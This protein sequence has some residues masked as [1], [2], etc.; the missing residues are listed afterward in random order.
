MSKIDRSECSPLQFNSWKALTLAFVLAF[1]LA[2]AATAFD[3]WPSHRV[4]DEF[5]QIRAGNA[6]TG[7]RLTHPAHP[8]PRFFETIH[9]FQEPTYSSKYVPGHGLV[10]A[11]GIAIGSARL[12]QWLAFATTA[13]ALLWMLAAWGSR[14]AAIV[15][16]TIFV[17]L[18]ADTPW[19]SGY[20]GFGLDGDW[21]RTGVRRLST[22]HAQPRP[23]DA[24]RMGVDILL[25]AFT[26][27]FESVAAC[28]AP[29]IV[30]A[31]WI[32][33]PNAT[34]IARIHMI[35]VPSTLGIAAGGCF[36]TDTLPYYVPHAAFFVFLLFSVFALRDWRL[37]VVAS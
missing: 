21:E 7:G 22:P 2:V 10:L 14:R 34:R 1:L 20:W 27:P 9:V 28:I 24:A 3:G 11:L 29:A 23:L 12:G 16:T 26:R 8:L 30:F 15:G 37:G 6:F 17:L 13:P 33:I 36:L 25:M 31:G 5:S 35:A 32:L 4:L 19:A 18:V